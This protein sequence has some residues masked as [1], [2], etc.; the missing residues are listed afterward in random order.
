MTAFDELIA[1][2]PAADAAEQRQAQDD[3]NGRSL[4]DEPSPS[5][6]GHNAPLARDRFASPSRQTAD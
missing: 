3:Q 1:Q 5:S 6:P 4:T 2:K